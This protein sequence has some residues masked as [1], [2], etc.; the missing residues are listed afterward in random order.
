MQSIRSQIG[1]VHPVCQA[2][3]C[4]ASFCKRANQRSLPNKRNGLSLLEVILALS[5]LGVATGIL[6]TIMQQ[7]AD[8]GLRSRRMTQA[9]MVCESKMGEAMAGA[10]PLQSTQWTP[11]ASMDGA[12]WY[13]SLEIIQAEQPNLIGVVIQVNDELA[14]KESQ[15]PLSR[16]VQWII[17]PSLGLDTKPTTT[18][19]DTTGQSTGTTGAAP[20]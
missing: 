16:L 9:Q 17:D 19:T 11:V 6:S 5:I 12:S 8:N 18:Q 20:S 7:S 13:Y 1:Q 10:L 4:R 2:I 14:M 3:F 15:R